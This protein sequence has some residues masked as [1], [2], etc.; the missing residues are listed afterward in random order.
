[1]HQPGE[2]DTGVQGSVFPTELDSQ[3]RAELE[4]NARDSGLARSNLNGGQVPELDGRP[5]GSKRGDLPTFR[6]A[7]DLHA[8]DK[9]P[10]S[11]NGAAGWGTGTKAQNSVQKFRPGP[12]PPSPT[13][14]V[15]G[16]SKN[17]AQVDEYERL[18]K[19]EE[20]LES[21]RRTLEELKGIQERQAQVRERMEKLKTAMP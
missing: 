4:G 18:R 6:S 20:E 3:M 7:K 10:P 16:M 21:R 13:P 11:P 8:T 14:V 5:R 9:N 19:E 1:M 2:L 17:P 15:S 12:K